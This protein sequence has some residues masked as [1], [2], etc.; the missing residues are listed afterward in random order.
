MQETTKNDCPV[1]I[2]KMY[3]YLYEIPETKIL[4]NRYQIFSEI[5]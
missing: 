5:Y 4:W 2:E 1:N 3:L